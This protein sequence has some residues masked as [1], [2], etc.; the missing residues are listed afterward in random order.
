MGL[1]AYATH[2]HEYQHEEHQAP[3]RKD[4]R[5]SG[6]ADKVESKA[7]RP[8]AR[9]KRKC[10]KQN[11]ACARCSQRGL[12]CQYPQSKPSS[13]SLNLEPSAI[14]FGILD[15]TPSLLSTN[16]LLTDS[17]AFDIDT[18]LDLP[19]LS[20]DFLGR[21]VPADWSWFSSADTWKIDHF[22]TPSAVSMGAD[23]L[24]RYIQLSQDWLERWIDTGSNPFIHAH[25]YE[26]RFPSSVQTAFAVLASYKARTESNT[27]TILRIVE[28]RA[29]ELLSLDGTTLD[30][31]GMENRS[32]EEVDITSVD[33]LEQLARVH[34]LI[35]YQ[36]ISLFDG[37][38][39]SR[40]L[41]ECRFPILVRWAHRAL[42]IPHLDASKLSLTTESHIMPPA[43]RSYITGRGCNTKWHT[44]VIAESIRRTWL[45]A[46][47]LPSVYFNLQQRWADCPGGIMF[48]NREGLWGAESADEWERL[49][50]DKNVAFIQRFQADRLFDEA[51]PNDVDEFGRTWLEFTFGPDRL[52]QWA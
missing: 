24:N 45:V 13:S 42:E 19:S 30:L 43:E 31:L 6:M 49:C 10:G 4:R 28:D 11:P 27:K 2:S 50:S 41:A 47:A 20:A 5:I 25:L 39:R 46:G 8:C 17:I 3:T 48:T 35:V 22:P 37:D 52:K 9:A 40:W 14:Q 1:G 26:H 15:E 36:S 34:A 44:W 29:A 33:L 7:C 32:D 16:L 21:N 51:V 23:D 38:I 12:E 18:D